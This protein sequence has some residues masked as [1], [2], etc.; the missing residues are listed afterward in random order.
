MSPRRAIALQEELRGR[1]RVRPLAAAP[2]LVAGADASC[3]AR[4]G[5]L[6]GA[7][8]VFSADRM[9]PV[10]WAAAWGRVS[11]PYVPGLLSFREAPILL[12]AFRRLRRRPD[13]V[14]FDGHGIAH[15]RGLG[16]ASHMGLLL[17]LPT[18]GCAKSRLV[19]TFLEPGR[20]A[21][22]RSPLMLGRRRIG[23]VLRTRDGTRPVFVS[24]G[25]LTDHRSA[26]RW[27]LRCCRGYRL[28]EPTRQ[29]HILVGGI[30][31]ERGGR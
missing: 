30:R 6:F 12:R 16:L 3:G 28:P 29:A 4:G 14:I 27:V 17:G 2:R 8:V 22:S 10:E 5:L 25:H 15:P 19:G 31:R 21:G 13:L 11:F 7:V 24:P 9:E 20:R 26:T 23:T 18:A 1:I